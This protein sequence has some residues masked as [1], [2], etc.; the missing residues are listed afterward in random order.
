MSQNRELEY[1][2]KTPLVIHEG[3]Q[4]FVISSTGKFCAKIKDSWVILSS[5]SDL[6]KR[7]SMNAGAVPVLVFKASYSSEISEPSRANL[8]AIEGDRLRSADR[9]LLDHRSVAY[10]VDEEILSSIQ[11]A[12]E[13]YRNAMNAYRLKVSELVGR[14]VKVTPA[15]LS[16]HRQGASVEAG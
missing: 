8:V 10:F 11:E 9:G 5:L 2:N 7:I 12:Q 6:R 4:I 3:V 14:L 1:A 13:E 16:A 15:S